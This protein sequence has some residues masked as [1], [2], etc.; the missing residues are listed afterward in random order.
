MFVALG[1]AT[2]K[3]NREINWDVP[4]WGTEIVSSSGGKLGLS[5]QDKIDIYTTPSRQPDPE[6]KSKLGLD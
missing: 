4:E 1:T 5:R 3:D 6:C 2:L